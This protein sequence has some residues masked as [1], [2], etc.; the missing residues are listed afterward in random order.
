MITD[1]IDVQSF[2]GQH[3]PRMIMIGPVL[4][5]PDSR[6]RYFY[7]AGNGSKVYET[8]FVEVDTNA[9]KQ[10]TDFIEKLRSRFAEAWTIRKSAVRASAT[11]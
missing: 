7:V 9:D 8:I 5:V 2:L 1:L 4:S 10:R 3:D 6:H 11:I